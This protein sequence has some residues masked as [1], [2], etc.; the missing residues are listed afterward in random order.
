M[1]RFSRRSSHRLVLHKTVIQSARL[2][3]VST[4]E[5]HAEAIFRSFTAEVTTYMFPKPAEQLEETL[6]FVRTSRVAAEAGTNLQLTILSNTDSEFLG[7]CGLHGSSSLR[8][9]ELGIWLK[10]QAHGQGYGKEAI[11]ALVA[12]ATEH[13]DVDGFVYPVD[14]RNLASRKIPE[15]LGG[16]IAKTETTT[17]LGGNALELVTYE[18]AVAP[19]GHD[20]RQTSVV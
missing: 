19:H 18:I 1:T 15:A 14:R 4:T 3:L 10:Q 6:A 12:W 5:A 13:L 8:T 2:R 17:G 16:K 9:P 7:C 11:V 20:R